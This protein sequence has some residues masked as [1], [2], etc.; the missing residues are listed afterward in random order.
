M[1]CEPPAA[2]NVQPILHGLLTKKLWKMSTAESERPSS[3][4]PFPGARRAARPNNRHD[5]ETQATTE[6]DEDEDEGASSARQVVRPVV[7]AS[8]SC[9]L[10][11]RNMPGCEQMLFA[12]L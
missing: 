4:R 7:D 2:V 3:A 9:A 6:E 11:R 10:L 5:V 12:W 8:L 1:Q